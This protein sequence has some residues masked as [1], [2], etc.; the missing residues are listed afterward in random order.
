MGAATVG[1]EELA[2]AIVGAVLKP[3]LM[4]V[5]VSVKGNIELVE[6]EALALLRVPLGFL[7]LAY[8]SIVH[9]KSPF[10]WWSSLSRP[11]REQKSTRT[12]ARFMAC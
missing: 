7:D 6:E 12:L 4:I 8:H 2:V 3:D 11:Y 1:G 9:R 10:R 5:V